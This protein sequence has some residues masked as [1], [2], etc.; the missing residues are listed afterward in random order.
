M[1]KPLIMAVAAIVMMSCNN[2]E[3]AKTDDGGASTP[4]P[5]ASAPAATGDDAA[6]TTWLGGK[7]LIA[8]NPA[9]AMYDH[10]KLNADGTCEDKDKAH[11]KWKV[12]GGQFV[13][14]GAMDVKTKIEKKSDTSIAFK[15]ALGDEMYTVAASK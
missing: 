6:L 13:F 10:L 12:E 14:Q 3:K 2:G 5:E 11:A 8:A 7:T 4:K 9:S 15:G 1:K